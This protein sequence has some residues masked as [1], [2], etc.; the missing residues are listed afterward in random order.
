[1]PG[2]TGPNDGREPVSGGRRAAIGCFT[3]WLG[4]VSGAMVAALAS[5]MMAYVTRAP[6][7]A[8]IPS[9]NWY[10]YAVVGGG[11]GAV[12][13]PLLV[14]WTL[15]RPAKGSNPDRGL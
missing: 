7:C 11:V 15:G 1:M 8:G 10:I 9:C 4:F 5:K 14:L 3:A 6:G 13:L 12:S 2:R